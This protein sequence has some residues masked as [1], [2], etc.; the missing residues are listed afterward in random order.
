MAF[1]EDKQPRKLRGEANDLLRFRDYA[2]ADA[3]WFWE[4]DPNYRFAIVSMRREGRST[5]RENDLLGK[6]P[7]E[8]ADADPDHDHERAGFVDKLQRREPFRNFRI[9]LRQSDASHVYWRLSGKPVLG[10]DGTFFGYRGIATDETVEA[11]R[12][13]NLEALASDYQTALE[14]LSE[15]VA[16]F[17]DRH[18]ISFTNPA[19][20][21]LIPLP[22][23]LF[24]PGTSY[25]NFVAWLT[26]LL[27]VDRRLG[28]K[29][30]TSLGQGRLDLY[31]EDGHRLEGEIRT[32][33]SGRHMMLVRECKPASSTGM[34]AKGGLFYQELAESKQ[35]FVAHIE[36]KIVFANAAAG[37]IFRCPVDSLVGSD[38]WN[39][40]HPD[41]RERLRAY[42]R[43]RRDGK[44]VPVS[45]LTR[46]VR[47][48]GEY[49]VWE[50]TVHMGVWE[51]ARAVQVFLQD[52]TVQ[53]QAE[54]ALIDSEMRYR[55]LVDG[56]IQGLFV[57]RNWEILF[58]N[59]A[60]AQ[61][62]GYDVDDF[63]G[64]NVMDI[65]S[66]DER[67]VIADIRRRRLAGDDDVPDR[68]EFLGLKSDGTEIAIEIF[69][70]LV[71]WDGS[72]A[73]QA[74]IMDVT[75][76]KQTEHNLLKAK[77]A[78]EHADRTKTEFLAN[79][80][81][82]L[83]TPLNAIIGFSQLIRDKIM[84][85]LDAHY[86]DYAGSIHASGM[87]LLE[88]VNDLLDVASIESG[89]ITLNNEEV[90]I[91]LIIRSCERMLRTRAQKA[92][93][94]I[95]VNISDPGVT[96]RGDARR[97]K[98]IL[99]N[100]VNNAIK[101]TRPGGHVVVHAY[102]SDANEVVLEVEDS[103]IGIS[104]ADQDVIFDAFTRVN[105]SFVSEREGT[106]LGLPL[107]H[108]LTEMHGGRITLDSEP[109]RG[110]KIAVIL[111]P[112]RL[113]SSGKD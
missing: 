80:S 89:A 113:I 9:S 62:F 104:K 21:K 105:S 8:F 87:H 94:L 40:I 106:G 11:I 110:T 92:E 50:F 25:G 35:P 37:D 100:L 98:Q 78:A 83:R 10:A 31:F 59:D 66:P 58:A 42:N 48:D 33:S 56:S 67:G 79:M 1:E 103:G 44:D 54:Q 70:S 96:V 73:I 30:Q 29:I 27:V 22:S 24:L 81:H 43:D 72:P 39:F 61:M 71:D 46:G 108:A 13:T 109:G 19:F 14:Q 64:R 15:G 82:E 20:R 2:D 90:E 5:V 84:G 74:T 4:L 97:L 57:H 17:D 99:I 88:V 26:P 112:E 53:H 41:E 6:T 47:A 63:I 102:L 45:Y 28:S 18:R 77:E 51:G 52:R 76:R 111:P 86:V 36:G 12:R 32:L 91:A 85:D 49:R 69:S 55:Y 60:A 65:V 38:L 93:L 107:V 34:I 3:D 95:S 7:W 75:R 68:Y 23:E 16:Y 101:F